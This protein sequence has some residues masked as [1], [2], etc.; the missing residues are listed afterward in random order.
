[1][2]IFTLKDSAAAKVASVIVGGAMAFTLVFGGAV[3]PAQAQ[4]VE[5]LTAQIN[6]LLATIASLQASL[7]GMTGGTTTTTTGVAYNFTKNLKQGDSGVDV[8]NLQKVL[9]MSTD[10]QVAVSGVGS[11]GLE[12]EYFGSMTKAAVIKFQ[13]KYA[14]EI[15][16]PVGLTAGTGFVGASTRAK[17]NTMTTTTTTGTGTG[18]TGTT[19]TPAGTGLTVSAGSQPAAS[20]APHGVARIPFTK[21]VL[22][23]SAD[24]AVTVNS[25]LVER[26]GL[27]QDAAFAG[28]ILLDDNGNQIGIAKTLN[29]LHQASVGEAFTIPAGTSKMV[30]IA[31]NMAASLTNYTGQVASLSVVGVNTSATVNGAFPI[32]GTSHTLNDSLTIG[33]ATA[34]RGI[35]DP[36]TDATKQ[37][38]VTGY[39]FSS[40]KVTA[41]SAEKIRIHSIRWN[42]SGSAAAGDLENVK[43]YVDGTAYATT[44]SADG[45]YYTTSFGSGLV[46]DKGLSK[47]ISIKG[48]IASGSGRTI[49]F[50]LYKNTDIYLTGE[51]YGYGITPGNGSGFSAT[52]PWYNASVVTVSNGTLT[53][54]KAV[55]VAA[56]NVSENVAN[57]P[58]GGFD[59]EVK[60]E[61]ISVA[62]IVFT[63][64]VSSG[65][66]KGED[67][68]SI[69]LVDA[70][71]SVV[72][73][74][75]DA[76]GTGTTATVTFSDTV[77]FPVGKGTYTLKGKLGTDF[78][79]DQTVVFA[80]IPGT[81]WTTVTGQSTGNSVTPAPAGAI[82]SNTMTMKAGTA[83]INNSASPV[84]QS[85]VA[86]AQGFTFANF[87]FD[88]TASGEDVRFTSLVL[89]L[90]AAS[91][92]S[93]L[94]GCQLFDG[95][96]ALNTGSN[97]KDITA[98]GSNT[99]TL[100]AGGVV[101]PKQTLKVLALKCNL[102]ASAT[103]ESFKWVM[104][105]AQTG[106][107]LVSGT[108]ITTAVPTGSGQTMVATS[109]G[110]LTV[111]IGNGSP[112]YKIA[113]AGTTDVELGVLKF[114]GT[115]E[116]ILL[117][118]LGLELTAA[119]SS[120]SDLT[121][122]TLWNG[123]TQVGTA[124]FQGTDYATST[125][126]GTFLI[127]KGQSKDM[128]IKGDLALI[129]TDLVGTQGALLK[130]N[131]DGGDLLA[132]YG[133]GAQSGTTIYSTSAS[134]TNVSGVRVFRAYPEFAKITVTDTTLVSRD[135][136]T[137]YKFSVTA[138]DA[139][140]ASQGIGLSQLVVNVATSTAS[141]VSGTTTVT[142]LKVY[143]YTDAAMSNTV[144][145][146][147][148][149]LL[150][151]ALA[152]IANGDNNIGF[153]SLLNIPAGTTYYFKVTG[154]TTLT[155]GTGTFSGSVS[156]KISGDSAYPAIAGLMAA[157]TTVAGDTNNDFVWSPHATT[158][159][160][161]AHIDWTNGYNVTGLPAD[162]SE[163]TTISK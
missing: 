41:G 82:T 116:D 81:N 127:P 98:A 76:V 47:E 96:T 153:T 8:L 86:G 92:P 13:N 30:T 83:V 155:A 38:G 19:T 146:F 33:T 102:S 22:T 56:Q 117:K 74:P 14:S 2:N 157:E 125:L 95:D 158:T 46:V 69:T 147:T 4:T 106:T 11:K 9:N 143:A 24:G 65:T 93:Y 94:T 59:V 123:N 16:T 35:D 129:G 34:D 44:V 40:A 3:A 52:T 5:E 161:A 29:S 54:S 1:M 145:G 132:T 25:I 89:S 101:I 28:V 137:L 108:T 15:L 67:I 149:G 130:V 111:E 121:R 160:E 18:T 124:T 20:L 107:G 26:T 57:E 144:S 31:G 71:G 73:G 58:L 37:V 162:G 68:T 70:N 6:S 97:I 131:Y 133:V 23:A 154:D 109:G 118:K 99:F 21:I 42:Q 103:S 62:S 63:G 135:D 48:D 75:V 105:A 85:I 122:V 87:Q 112:S 148:N 55:S 150:A 27:A 134:D 140:G 151:T 88:A 120:P 43:T 142:D 80:T 53:V 110:T 10:T 72:A 66:G 32:V 115:N 84:A 17:L 64:T 39:V 12:S 77:T 100:D 152:T 163:T 51:T 7:S 90:T 139:A 141:T 91:N 126:T 45:K 159:S 50:D 113:A 61:A 49:A 114:T 78:D 104:S 79:N 119:S 138:K 60:G 36:N 128:I 136:M 156:T